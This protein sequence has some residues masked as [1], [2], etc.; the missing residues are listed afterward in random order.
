MKPTGNDCREECEELR[1]RAA[2][3][4]FRQLCG[5][6]RSQGELYIIK[7]AR[8]SSD[9]CHRCAVC[10][11]ATRLIQVRKVVSELAAL[12]LKSSL[13]EN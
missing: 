12:L 9:F 6:F 2:Q 3:I 7:S 10:C 4:T 1:R 8:F 13:G 5:S 11:E